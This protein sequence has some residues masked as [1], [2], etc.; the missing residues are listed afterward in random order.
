MMRHT[1]WM[2]IC[3]IASAVFAQQKY[4]TRRFDENSGLPHSHATQILQDRKGMIWIATWNGLC[5]YDGY[6]FQRMEARRG[7]GNGETTVPD[8]DARNGMPSDRIR[9][10]WLNDDG[11]GIFCLV[12]DSLFLFDLQ[13]CQFQNVVS[14]SE[15]DRGQAL[16]KTTGSRGV[17]DGKTIN[18]T[19]RQGQEWQLLPYEIVCRRK[20]EEPCQVVAQPQ[21]AQIRCLAR[22]RQGRY[23]I[24][25]KEDATLRLYDD[26]LRLLG[27]VQPD[28]RLTRQAGSWKQ[29]VYCIS[30]AS[31]GSIWIG[32]KPGGLSR[33]KEADGRFTVEAIDGLPVPNVYDI[34]EDAQGRLWIATLGGGICCIENPSVSHPVPS[35]RFDSYPHDLAKKVR[36]IHLIDKEILMATTTD[37]LIVG[38]M[39]ADISKTRFRLHRKEPARSTSLNCNATMDILEDAHRRLFVSTESGGI[40]EIVSKDLTADTLTFRYCRMAGG[41]PTDAILSMA[42]HRGRILATSHN[43]LID[44]DPRREEG[45]V[46][47][48]TFFGKSYRFSE[49]RPLMTDEGQWLLGAAEEALL[50]DTGKMQRKTFVPPLV[51]T[52]IAIQ[53][54]QDNLA[55][56]ELDTLRLTPAERTL[57]IRFAAL[58]YTNP[59]R[60]RYAYR[61]GDEQ[62]PWNNLGTDHS[63]TLL[64][65]TPGTYVLSLRSTNGDG[66]WVD[67]CRRLVIIVEPTFW[68]TPWA[69]VLL[70]AI[71]LLIAGIVAYTLFYIRRV[72]RRKREIL[73]AYLA[74]LEQGRSQDTAVPQQPLPKEPQQQELTLKPEDDAF[75]KRVVTFV[76]DHLGDSDINIGDMANAAAVSRSG[77]QRKMKQ[78]MGV[79][80]IDFL[81]EARIKKACRLLR[82]TDLAIV[83]IAY[84]CG[85]SDPKY[86]SKTFKTSVGKSPSEYKSAPLTQ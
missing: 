59:Q 61:M 14:K 50:L 56:D 49:V 17:F 13:T 69:A 63:L 19:D 47:D 84:R 21:P 4:E 35:T 71:G 52:S 81:R 8:G 12:E 43:Q 70:T 75:M 85:F 24:S 22:D 3:M 74:L 37:G 20:K 18:F 34:K 80:P 83:D 48:G 23:W 6:T 29:P 46:Y 77:L 25:T 62:K 58:D 2:M 9:D 64:D 10:I 39:A 33:L 7:D 40:N 45:S 79:T 28:G 55:A 53:N 51:L 65:M 1:V 11:R 73:E 68:E 57:S 67:N 76:E 30:Q 15:H 72:N 66:T 31:D 38:K 60:I 82:E 26:K 78:L 42:A 27:Y 44:Y 54:G 32:S 36:F 41:W 16:R 5:R 86:F